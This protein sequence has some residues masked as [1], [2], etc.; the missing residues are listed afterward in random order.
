[1]IIPQ[2]LHKG[3]GVRVISPAR[4]LGILSPGLI[5]VANK[6]FSELGYSVSFGQHAAERD[7]QDSS[8]IHSRIE[9]LHNAFNDP[10]VKIIFTTIGGFNSNQLLQYI[11]YELIKNNPKIFCGYS[12]ITALANAI[13]TKTGLV[14]YSGPHYS[15]FGEKH[16]F[17]YTQEYFEKCVLNLDP[18]FIYPS[19]E[20]SKDRWHKDQENRN[21]IKNEGYWTINEGKASGT[22]I[23]GNLCTLNLLQGTEYMPDLNNTILF[24]ED[25]SLSN[26]S[27][28]DRDLVSLMQ[29][30]N[31][32]GVK[33]I[34][35]GRFEKDSEIL[36]EDVRRLIQSKKEL[37]GIPVIANVD[38]GHTDPRITFPIGGTAEIIAEKNDSKIQIINH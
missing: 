37:A 10:S 35:I 24:I 26:Y 15:S 2:K 33:G 21:T 25:D 6:R 5:D 11:D 19:K 27:I 12:D 20:W 31:F 22:V 36:E 32:G 29:Q 9:D 28:F 4:S 1:M 34:I 23:G 18:F 17:E 7:E 8:P 3:D 13:Y 30:P 38:F 14:T 16:Y